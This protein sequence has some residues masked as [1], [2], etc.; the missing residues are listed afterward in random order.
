M[1]WNDPEC[2]N[3]GSFGPIVRGCRAEF[4][5][6]TVFEQTILSILPSVCFE[7]LAL[8]RLRI[9]WHRPVII[10]G[11]KL[12]AWKLVSCLKLL[13]V[14]AARIVNSPTDHCSYLHSSHA[15]RPDPGSPGS[16]R[17]CPYEYCQLYSVLPER[18]D[19]CRAVLFGA[20]KDYATVHDTRRLSYDNPPVRLCTS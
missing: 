6:T 2:L 8:A 1:A 3:D 10:G 19:N 18:C 13:R 20:C 4:D 11:G 7:L 17:V 12:R 5:F 15:R 9:L 14:T 16:N